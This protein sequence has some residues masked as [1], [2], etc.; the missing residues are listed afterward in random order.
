MK[1]QFLRLFW[2]IR[3]W[4]KDAK[5][6]QYRTWHHLKWIWIYFG[7]FSPPDTF[8]MRF[9]AYAWANTSDDDPDFEDEENPYDFYWEQ[10]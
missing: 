3:C 10:G 5:Y 1:T 8:G 9:D 2:T 7:F 4:F 6:P